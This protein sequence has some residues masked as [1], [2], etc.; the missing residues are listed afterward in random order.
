MTLPVRNT[1][2]DFPDSVYSESNDDSSGARTEPA[3][4]EQRRRFFEA[5]QA[6]GDRRR[7][8]IR[9]QDGRRFLAAS[10]FNPFASASQ[11]ARTTL[12]MRNVP[13]CFPR[14]LL[15]NL[16]DR[17]GFRGMY[18]FVYLP[19]DYQTNASLGYAF[20]NFIQPHYA[21]LF[22]NHFDGF[23][24]W[25]VPTNKVCRLDWCRRFQGYRALVEH[26]RNSSVMHPSL[27]HE[28]KPVVFRSGLQVAFPFPTRHIRAPRTALLG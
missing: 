21:H 20:I 18:D 5:D 16:I 1:F 4:H 14:R 25:G 17:E 10:N 15:L 19:I 27:L 26:Y 6:E 12:V 23:G 3:G 22:W 9:R 28:H 24:Q 11:D 7:G 2:I 8:R 13:S